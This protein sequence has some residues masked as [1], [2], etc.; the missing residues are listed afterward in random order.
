[1]AINSNS[2]NSNAD[3]IAQN[4]GRID[5]TLTAISNAPGSVQEVLKAA[6][7]SFANYKAT[8]RPMLDNMIAGVDKPILRA[9]SQDVVTVLTSWFENPQLLCCLVQGIYGLFLSSTATKDLSDAAKDIAKAQTDFNKWIDFVI[10]FVDVIITILGSKVKKLSFAI[11]DFIKEIMD[12]VIGAI[13]MVLQEL[14]FAIRDSI[15][16]DLLNEIERQAQY[17]QNSIWAKCLPLSQLLEIIRKYVSDFGLFAELFEKIK[18]YIGAKVGDFGYM[19]AFDFPNNIKDLE[20]LYWFRDL[21]VKLKAAMISFDLCFLP[22]TSSTGTNLNTPQVLPGNPT[23][24]NSVLQSGATTDPASVMGV[25]VG[26]DGTILQDATKNTLAVLTNSSVRGFLNKFYG[27]PLDVV[28][29]LIVGGTGADSIHGTNITSSNP[30]NLNAD[31]PNSPTPAAIVQWAL[32][33]RA[34]NI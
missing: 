22:Q 28:D 5:D 20:F 25:T 24:P 9:M 26:A 18:G 8:S 4:Q 2:P 27:Y 7:V 19:K 33:V 23:T 11:P 31:C 6:S 30:S 13:L 29:A 1:M 15:I 32:Q 3:I 17:G 21:L 10:V 16:N 34:R 12:G 14:L